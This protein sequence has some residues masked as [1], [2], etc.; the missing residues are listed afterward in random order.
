VRSPPRALQAAQG[1]PVQARDRAQPERQGGL[2]LGEGTGDEL[3]GA[4]IALFFLT[5]AAPALA[6][7]AAP[8][9]AGQR[10][11][12]L[13][14]NSWGELTTPGELELAE[15]ELEAAKHEIDRVV[16]L[17][18]GW[19]Y[20]AESS[21]A[22]YQH[23]IG[24]LSGGQGLPPR[25]FV[26]G[27]GWD[28]SLTGFRKLVNDVVPL[29][30]IANAIAW[31]PDHTLFPLSFWSKAATADRIGF[32][33]LRTAMNRLL[34]HADP[35]RPPG[36]LLIGHSFGTRVVSALVLEHL[37][38]LPVRAEPFAGAAQV[39]GMMLFQ[40]A[41][42]PA[43]LN[44]YARYPVVVTMSRH[45]HANGFLFPVANVPL[46]AFGFTA[47]EALLRGPVD[48][49]RASARKAVG[50]VR[51]AL[52]GVRE[53]K[54]PEPPPSR[55]PEDVEFQA[56]REMPG[57]G[58]YVL[59]RTLVEV[60]ALPA[61]LAFTLVATPLNYAY[62]QGHGLV[63]NPVTH[64]LDTLAQLPLVEIPVDG[65]SWALGREVPFGQRSKGFLEFGPVLEPVGRLLSPVVTGPRLHPPVSPAAAFDDS[66]PC[67][68]VVCEGLLVVDAS[69]HITRGALGENLGNPF[70][71]YTLGWLDP[72]GAHGDYRNPEV[73]AA[74]RRIGARLR[75]PR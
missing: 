71:D 67:G 74:V 23:M 35:E 55:Q 8:D 30:G 44:R 5:C 2:S 68:L 53:P 14:F 70:W 48:L 17:S 9:G 12:V 20:E 34:S 26:I 51:K 65:L 29:P 75:Q 43:N 49:A 73:V 6:Q 28:S 61:A 33:G 56:L 40:P 45:D 41:S 57:Q 63:R 7:Q 10:I 32:G 37:G 19:A 13:G 11:F 39:E 38:I 4:A 47:F 18:Y 31:I 58:E 59:R 25:T 64:V 22:S 3:I 60:A 21:Y 46:N 66:A 16:V 62:V 52:P 15:R 54:E 69:D 24:D 50:A 42:V 36:I 1:V 72:I 27:V